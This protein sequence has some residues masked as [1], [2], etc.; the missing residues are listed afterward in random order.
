MRRPRRSGDVRRLRRRCR[1][2]AGLL[3]LWS[4]SA[5]AAPQGATPAPV[6]APALRQR[7]AV[8]VIFGDDPSQPWIQPMSDAISRVLYGRGAESPEPYYEYLD[9]ARFPDRAHRDLFRDTIRRKY[10]DLRF[11][12]IIPVAG[13]AM[14]FV[15]DVRDELWPGVPVLFTRYNANQPLGVP[16]REHDLVLGFEFSLQAALE[17]IKAVVP[18]TTHVAVVWDEDMA[19][20]GQ[21]TGAASEFRRLDLQ[22]ID[23]NGLP[24]D[25]LVSRLGRLPEHAVVLLGVSGGQLDSAHWMNPAWPLC[26]VASRAANRPTFMLGAHFLGCGIVGG[27]LRDFSSIGRIVG[28]RA[29]SA[30]AGR[31][32]PAEVIPLSE[33]TEPAFDARQ[34]D[35]WHIDEDRLPAGSVV[36][37]RQPSLWRDFRL[38]V[39]G[40][41]GAIGVLSALVGWLLYERR[42]RREAERDSRRSL[43]MAAHAGRAATMSALTGSIGHELSQPLGSIR[44]NAEAADQLIASNRATPEELRDIL[45]DIGREDERATRIIE[46]LRAMVKKQQDIDKRPLDVCAVVRESL[47]I[48]AHDASARHVQIDCRLPSTPCL[49]LGDQVLLQQVMINLMLNAFDA[50]ANADGS[51]ERRILIEAALRAAVVDI[52][53]RDTGPGVPVE[54]NGRLF[55]PFVTT[56]PNG[57]GLGLSIVSSIVAAHG[58]TIGSHNAAEGGAVFCV[59]LPQQKTA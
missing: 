26:E 41:V 12:L 10:G 4:W 17:T 40:T 8:L 15:N 55:E 45:R 47:A 25:D 5:Q 58:G 32:L 52:S 21:T 56:K 3:I 37:F 53:I 7:P 33:F 38:Q 43:A 9:A 2:A 46:R 16:V 48:L 51:A 49:I 57:L 27:L 50:M 22:A 59:T 39:F 28:E 31:Q 6:A 24:L 13:V 34:L 30:L 44:L 54:L 18:G 29:L 14:G 35:R 19:G 42:G 1:I 11:S 23:L 20:S 36:R